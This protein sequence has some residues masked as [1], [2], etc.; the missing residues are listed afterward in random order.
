MALMDYVARFIYLKVI[1]LYTVQI[2]LWYVP[3]G[4]VAFLTAG[5][6]VLALE[7]QDIVLE[8]LGIGWSMRVWVCMGMYVVSFAMRM[9]E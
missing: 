8:A 1:A 2:W 9:G 6:F 7:C 3:Y 4:A 5:L